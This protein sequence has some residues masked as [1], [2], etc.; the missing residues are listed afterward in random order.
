MRPKGRGPEEAREVAVLALARPVLG[1]TGSLNFRHSLA[2]IAETAHEAGLAGLELV[3]NQRSVG[4]AIKEGASYVRGLAVPVLS[5]HAPYRWVQGWGDLASSLRRTIAFAREAG[6]PRV[7][8]HPPTPS[9]LQMG[10]AMLFWGTRDFQ[11]LGGGKVLISLENMPASV[12]SRLPLSLHEPAN[13][14]GFLRARNLR[15]TFD[16]THFAVGHRSP[17][18]ALHELADLMTSVH[19]NNAPEHGLHDH[20]PP[21]LGRLDLAAFVR[22]LPRRDD[23]HL[24][25][26]IDFGL[27]TLPAIRRLWIESVAFVRRHTEPEMRAVHPDL[28]GISF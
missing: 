5:L 16:T 4:H 13:L 19:L 17:T 9:S 27:L 18:H 28:S 10:H 20:R 21:H 22:Q 2:E 8:F 15:L 23:L 24:V 6:V 11:A 14:A 1:S 25:L 7:V 3:M 12:F 26:E